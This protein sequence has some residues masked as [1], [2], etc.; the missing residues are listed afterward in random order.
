MFVNKF[1]LDY[2]YL[3][4]DC[5]EEWLYS[6]TLTYY[7]LRSSWIRSWQ[8]IQNK[9]FN[10]KK[11]R[12]FSIN[13]VRYG[14]ILHKTRYQIIFMWNIIYVFK[15]ILTFTVKCCISR[16]LLTIVDSHRYKLLIENHKLAYT[17]LNMKFPL[18][19]FTEQVNNRLIF[20][21]PCCFY[22]RMGK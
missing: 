4:L 18:M 17:K 3:A 9:V 11:E 7:A 13:C 20:W 14:K 6:R 19:K 1:H 2:Q 21:S 12:N 5:L 10:S 16:I 22:I 15:R 8:L